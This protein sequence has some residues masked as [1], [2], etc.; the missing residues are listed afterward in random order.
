MPRAIRATLATNKKVR[1][2]QSMSG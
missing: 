2:P 1:D